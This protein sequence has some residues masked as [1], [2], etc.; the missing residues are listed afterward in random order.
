MLDKT[1][2]NYNYHMNYYLLLVMYYLYCFIFDINNQYRINNL[3]Y[4]LLFQTGEK[5]IPAIENLIYRL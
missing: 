1:Q 5:K 3:I 2:V 4:L